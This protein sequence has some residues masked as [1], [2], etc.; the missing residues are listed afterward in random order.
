MTFALL[1]TSYIAASGGR[2]RSSLLSHLSR[3]IQPGHFI[4]ICD[5][6]GWFA[7]CKHE[8]GGV[9]P[10]VG[11]CMLAAVALVGD[12]SYLFDAFL[13]MFPWVTSCD[14]AVLMNG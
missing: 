9:S 10:L 14:N 5:T 2:F 3:E 1:F 4:I 7:W 8:R 13:V 11:N 6:S 12:P